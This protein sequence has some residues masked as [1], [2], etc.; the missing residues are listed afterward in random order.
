MN[1]LVALGVL[2]TGIAVV[3]LAT[4][5]SAAPRDGPQALV[6]VDYY[7][8]DC[9][10]GP[11]LIRDEANPTLELEQLYAMHASG[12][13]SMG[14]VINYSTDPSHLNDNHGGAVLIQPDGTLGEPYRSRLIRYL[15]DVRAAGFAN[16]TLRFQPHGP[17]SP[18]PWTSGAPYVDDWNPS[19]YTADLH[20]IEDVHSLAKQYGPPES[21][22]DILA[23]GP[24]SDDDRAQLGSRIDDYISRLYTDYVDAYGNADVFFSAIDKIPA[25]DDARLAHLIEDLKSTGRP[26]PQ[27]WGL[28]IEYTGEVAARNL[29]D[30]GATLRSYGVSGS[31][32]LEETAYESVPVSAAVKSY[33]ATGSPP[34]VEVEEYPNWGEPNCWSAPYTGDAYLG[35]LGI[36]A[37]ALLGRVGASGKPTLTTSDGIPVRALA[38][39]RQYTVLVTDASRKAG[40]RLS[41]PGLKWHTAARFRGKVTWTIHVAGSG[42]SYAAVTGRKV[43]SV[44]FDTLTP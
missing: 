38:T 18:Q 9:H 35:V 22:F 4:S 29:A 20:F 39:G 23:E 21:H 27:W 25:G 31:L 34:V 2:V 14:L 10:G 33:N 8:T 28:D 13:N 42:W 30:A 6:G 17:N 11:Q 40:F 5:A 32:A 16:V 7:N 3:S 36:P 43:R 24:P 37:E 15:S 41:G 44:A 12:L 19:L 26:L 1:R